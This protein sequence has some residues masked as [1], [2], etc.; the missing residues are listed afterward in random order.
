MSG[1]LKNYTDTF[2]RYAPEVF[3]GVLTLGGGGGYVISLYN[4]ALLHSLAV[5]FTV[6][7]AWGIFVVIWNSRRFIDNTYLLFIEIAYLFVAFIDLIHTL[8]YKGIIIFLVVSAIE[9]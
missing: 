7:I 9:Y 5:L 8:A 4:Y 3:L 6:V 1:R 2:R